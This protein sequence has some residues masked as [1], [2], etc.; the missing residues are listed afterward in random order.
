MSIENCFRSFVVY[1]D[2]DLQA[3]ALISLVNHLRQTLLAQF[4]L[5]WTL[6]FICDSW[7]LFFILFIPLSVEQSG[8]EVN[9]LVQFSGNSW[10]DWQ[11]Y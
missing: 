4:L 8:F 11:L 5:S 1:S 7:G 9:L 2:A 6:T 10:E 3:L